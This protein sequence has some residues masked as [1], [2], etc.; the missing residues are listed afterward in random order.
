MWVHITGGVVGGVVVLAFIAA[1]VVFFLV[2]KH[3]AKSVAAPTY[4]AA[5]NSP[6]MNQR[7][8]MYDNPS[9]S[10]NPVPRLYV[11]SFPSCI[12]GRN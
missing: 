7:H 2:R 9:Y 12:Y 8:S 4:D 1:L 3:S 11:C 6:T 5:M 10:E